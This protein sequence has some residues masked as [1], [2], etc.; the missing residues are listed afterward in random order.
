MEGRRF[1]DSSVLVGVDH[2]QNGRA[3]FSL[4]LSNHK[5]SSTNRVEEKIN[6]G[7]R[8]AEI[9]ANILARIKFITRGIKHGQLSRFKVSIFHLPLL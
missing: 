9:A 4:G 8:S 5:S 2:L 3:V 1:W 6:S 7:N